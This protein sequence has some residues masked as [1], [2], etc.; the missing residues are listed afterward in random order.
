MN[1]KSIITS[2]FWILIFS[3]AFGYSLV[4]SG[5]WAVDNSIKLLQQNSRNIYLNSEELSTIKLL[6]K[7]NQNLSNY[8]IHTSCNIKTK[9][10][11]IEWPYHEFKLSFLEKCSDKNFTLTDYRNK[12]KLDL[13][14]NFISEY[15]LLSVFLDIN[16]KHLVRLK[17]ALNKKIENYSKYRVYNRNIEKD[18]TVFLKKNKVLKET[19]Y[20]KQTIDNIIRARDEKYMVP[21]SWYKLPTR[22]DKIPN[23]KRPYRSQYTD[24]IHHSWDIDTPLW[25][26]VVSLDDGIIVRVVNNWRWADFDKLKYWNLSEEQK[27]RNLD[28][29]RGNQVWLKTMKGEVV[30][31]WHLDKIPDNVVEWII[32]KKGQFLWTVWVTWV[33]DKKYTDYHLDFSI[34]K[35]PFTT[36]KI[37]RYSFYDYMTWDWLFKWDSKEY[38]L[39]NQWN[40]FEG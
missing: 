25:E 39:K 10:S 17:N 1:K 3:I 5:V 12:I 6:F 18:Y 32:V 14:L 38:I 24:W 13:K 11:H 31:Y 20:F 4:F 8:K 7:S 33:P 15:R 22:N 35:N 2:I 29:L 36:S 37:G 40:Y 16:T 28:I 34:S 30:F 23:A 27:R 26:K 9:Y 21:V 19:Q